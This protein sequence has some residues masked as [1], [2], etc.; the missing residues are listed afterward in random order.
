M[1]V[2]TNRAEMNHRGK[3]L[4]INKSGVLS[5]SPKLLNSIYNIHEG[6]VYMGDKR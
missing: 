3:L 2:L 5:T 6:I 1:H 4:K